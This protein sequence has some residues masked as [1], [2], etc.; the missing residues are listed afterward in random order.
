M[1]RTMTLR[2]DLSGQA[3]DLAR[4]EPHW[5]RPSSGR[6]GRLPRLGPDEGAPVGEEGPRVVADELGG[7]VDGAV[8]AGHRRAVVTPPADRVRALEGLVAGEAV[9]GPEP[10]ADDLH[11][12]AYPARAD[13]DLGRGGEVPRAHQAHGDH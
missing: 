6:A 9:L 7:R 8:G 5:A 11:R 4:A 10:R 3:A 1:A 12:P 2:I 13:V